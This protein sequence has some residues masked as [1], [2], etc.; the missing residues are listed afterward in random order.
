MAECFDGLVHV[1]EVFFDGSV[2]VDDV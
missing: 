1:G 2:K